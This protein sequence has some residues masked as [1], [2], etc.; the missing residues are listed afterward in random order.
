[1]RLPREMRWPQSTDSEC[2]ASAATYVGSPPKCCPSSILPI[3]GKDHIVQARRV[4][5]MGLGKF[6][7]S[8]FRLKKGGLIATS[9]PYHQ[10][11]S[12]SLT[13]KSFLLRALCNTWS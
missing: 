10:V 7:V 6:A 1:M 5:G 13:P 11:L 4:G 12:A 8:V 2:A 3:D 9:S